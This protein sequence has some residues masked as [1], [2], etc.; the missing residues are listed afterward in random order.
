MSQLTS[1][2]TEEPHPLTPHL[3]GETK[4]GGEM[5][6]KEPAER[7]QQRCQAAEMGRV[8]VGQM[9]SSPPQDSGADPPS[10]SGSPASGCKGIALIKPLVSPQLT[11]AMRPHSPRAS[12]QGAMEKQSEN[13]FY[14]ACLS[15]AWHT[16]PHHEDEAGTRPPFTRPPSRHSPGQQGRA[17]LLPPARHPVVV[18]LVALGGE[19]VLLHDLECP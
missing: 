8:T 17:H 3:E 15:S 11:P 14:S 5:E 10:T 1:E 18:R 12:C 7:C 13:H 19:L 4:R 9:V 16:H 2:S 6:H